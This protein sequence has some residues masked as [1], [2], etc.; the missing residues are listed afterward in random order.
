MMN[1]LQ[2]RDKASCRCM[3]FRHPHATL[4]L[5]HRKA[6]AGTA[7]GYKLDGEAEDGIAGNGAIAAFAVSQRPRHIHEP[8]VADVHVL[9][10]GGEA[11]GQ[12]PHLEVG[13]A[14]S[15]VG[16]AVGPCGVE[17]VTVA[18]A[19]RRQEPTLVAYA[20]RVGIERA[21]TAGAAFQHVDDDVVGDGG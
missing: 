13:N 15:G 2:G 18:I 3:L 21:P 8:L 6:A 10:G 11:I 1:L 12:N 16:G 14:C 17:H 5:E 7:V 19:R 20:D 4:G 9:Q